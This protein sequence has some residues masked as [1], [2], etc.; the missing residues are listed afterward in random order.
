[1]KKLIV[2]LI[3]FATCIS[4]GG[5]NREK[6]LTKLVE[7]DQDMADKIMKEIII[8]LDTGDSEALKRQFS[9]VTIEK[10]KNL[11]KQIEDLMNFYQGE[12]KEY[13]GN[14]DSGEHNK[15]GT[16]VEKSLSGNY[17]FITEKE[18]YMVS[19]EYKVID[20]KCSDNE[21]L[22][23]LEFVTEKVYQN[24]IETQGYYQWQYPDLGA[25]VYNKG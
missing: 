5:C 20:E 8:A 9:R 2:L 19:W 1:M 6:Q 25:G 13:E 11:D 18:T 23:V 4:L 3:C 24:S 21:G 17:K 12:E 16:I 15:H 7:S 10:D 14:A 22:S